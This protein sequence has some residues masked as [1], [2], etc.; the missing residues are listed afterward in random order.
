[1]APLM[2]RDVHDYGLELGIKSKCG[3]LSII[4]VGG[5]RCPAYMCLFLDH[6]SAQLSAPAHDCLCLVPTGYFLPSTNESTTPGS[7]SVEMSPRSEISPSAI[8]RSTRRIIL[9]E[10]VLGSAG[11]N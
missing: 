2:W 7:A 11:V 1:M 9:P 4:L 6:Q 8:L 5:A 3:A 10:R